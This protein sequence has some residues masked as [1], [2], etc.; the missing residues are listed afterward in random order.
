MKVR[1]IMTREV[2]TALPDTAV[3]LVARLM[4]VRILQRVGVHDQ[5]A[6]REDAGLHVRLQTGLDML[7]RFLEL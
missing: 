3:N 4:A 5:D 6:V 2:V 7:R 1:E